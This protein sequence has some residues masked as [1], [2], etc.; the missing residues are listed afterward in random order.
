VST[1]DTASGFLHLKK[2]R[3]RWFLSI[4]ENTLPQ[5]A[6]SNGKRTYRSL[7]IE[8]KEIEFSE[9][10]TDLHTVSYKHILDGHGFSIN[11]ALPSIE[12][13]HNIRN[14]KSIGVKGDYHP[15]I[16]NM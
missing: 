8:Q 9:G 4:N 15:F 6:V 7:T 13:T 3:V 11:D 2:A 10:F 16:K 5:V 1:A 12:L 14:A